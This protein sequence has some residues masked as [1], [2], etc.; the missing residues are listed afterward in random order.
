MEDEK[1]RT[2]TTDELNRLIKSGKG[3]FLIL[4]N[5]AALGVCDYERAG[6]NLAEI[7]ERG[8]VAYQSGCFIEVIEL[9]MQYM[10]FWLRMY[11]VVKN[12]AGA[13][14]VENDRRTFGRVI[15]DCEEVGLPPRLVKRLRAFN[16]DRI[17]AVHKYLL[18][19]TDYQ[20][21]RVVCD[22]HGAL[23]EVVKEY[24]VKAVGR[25]ATSVED[26]VGSMLLSRIPEPWD[27]AVELEEG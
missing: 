25:P 7:P 27:P 24:V 1:E 17:E 12:D 16:T 3:T 13:V 15:T 20:G 2:F 9:R 4:P 8:V 6:R 11:W 21:L 19:A 22:S 18:G 10:D 23:Q 14:F 26:T 5:A